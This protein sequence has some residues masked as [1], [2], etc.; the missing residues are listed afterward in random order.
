MLPCVIE[1]HPTGGVSLCKR[2]GYAAWRRYDKAGAN[3]TTNAGQGWPGDVELDRRQTTLGELILRQ[4][5][6]Q[7]MD[8]ATVIE[9]ILDGQMLMSSV[10]NFS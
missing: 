6:I 8:D 7:S 3:L 10:V 2:S 4:G 5:T 1:Y 9:I